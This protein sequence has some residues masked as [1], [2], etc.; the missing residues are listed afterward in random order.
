MVDYGYMSLI[1]FYYKNITNSTP[2]SLTSNWASLDA[3]LEKKNGLK[4]GG[5]WAPSPGSQPPLVCVWG[6]LLSRALCLQALPQKTNKQID[7]TEPARAIMMQLLA[8]D[9]F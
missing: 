3:T 7:Y 6:D 9:D 2:Q 8:N 1:Y 4:V 5:G